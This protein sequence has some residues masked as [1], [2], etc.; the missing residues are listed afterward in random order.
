MTFKPS[1]ASIVFYV[2]DIVRTE[3]FYNETLGL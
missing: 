2:S 3:K 1:N